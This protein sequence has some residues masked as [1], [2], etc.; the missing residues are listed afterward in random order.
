MTTATK[1]LEIKVERTIPAPPG[2]VFDAWL[3]PKIPG[4]PWHENEKL[5]A[6]PKVDGLWYWLSVGGHAS[7][8]AV[9]GNETARPD[10]AFL[11]V[12]PYLGRGIDGDGDIPE[13]GRRHAH[14]A[15][16][17]RPSE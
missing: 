9:Y 16:A 17:F 4:S 14:D 15:R 12:A 7:L 13:K 2:E 10:P 5:I 8:W 6:D 11:D 1:T 3:D